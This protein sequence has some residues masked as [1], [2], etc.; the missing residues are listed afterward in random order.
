M[1]DDDN[2]LGVCADQPFDTVSEASSVRDVASTLAQ[3][4]V[5]TGQR[6]HHIIA[7]SHSDMWYR[8][9]I[10]SWLPGCHCNSRH[11][12]ASVTLYE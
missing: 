10:I 8:C 5:T 3:S 7:V 11:A 2:C 4:K 12:T 6:L 9:C 1:S